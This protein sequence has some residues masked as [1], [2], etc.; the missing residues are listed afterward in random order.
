[1]NPDRLLGK[2]EVVF[3]HLLADSQGAMQ[4][5]RRLRYSDFKRDHCFANKNLHELN[6]NFCHIANELLSI[7]KKNS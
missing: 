1:M 5:Q 3:R 6:E 2:D 4:C 7:V